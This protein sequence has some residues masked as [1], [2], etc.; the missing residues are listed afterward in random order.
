MAKKENSKASGSR[1][2]IASSS[3]AR[4]TTA[5]RRAAGIRETGPSARQSAPMLDPRGGAD[6]Y[7]LIFHTFFGRLILLG[8]GVLVV[9]IIDL[10]LSANNFDRFT[11][12]LGIELIVAALVGWFVYLWRNRDVIFDGGE[13]HGE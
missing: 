1:K 3:S 10:L 8:L 2:G 7:A 9:I 6:L 5:R 12:I 11:L 4:E 13:D